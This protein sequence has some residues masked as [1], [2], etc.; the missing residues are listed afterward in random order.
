MRWWWAVGPAM[1]RLITA[2]AGGASGAPAKPLLPSLW[3]HE[4]WSSHSLPWLEALTRSRRDQ[5][6]HYVSAVPDRLHPPSEKKKSLRSAHY[7][8][9]RTRDSSG[10][11]GGNLCPPSCEPQMHPQLHEPA[12]S[13]PSNARDPR[14]KVEVVQPAP[15]RTATPAVKTRAIAGPASHN[16]KAHP[17]PMQQDPKD[18]TPEAARHPPSQ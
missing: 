5:P 7:E 3:N 8:G 18:T 6:T 4:L 10:I 9:G 13:A 17:S 1:G 16:R 2:G 14:A 15:Q 11:H 12:R